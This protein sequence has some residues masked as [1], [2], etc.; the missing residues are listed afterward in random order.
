MNKP[1]YSVITVN[2][3]A[4]RNRKASERRASGTTTITVVGSRA[5]QDSKTV[6]ARINHQLGVLRLN[7]EQFGTNTFEFL[8]G[9]A[10]GADTIGESV[11]QDTGAAISQYPADWNQFGKS[12]GLR[13]NIQMA[14][15]TDVLIA[16]WDMKSTGTHHMLRACRAFNTMCPNHQMDIIIFNLKGQKVYHYSQGVSSPKPKTLKSAF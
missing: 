9:G 4:F 14:A 7:R 15:K 1:N 16:F 6:K 3:G 10:K 13:R 8:C 11:A 2:Q 5:G 12:A